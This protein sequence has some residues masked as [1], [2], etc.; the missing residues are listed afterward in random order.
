MSKSSQYWEDRF[1]TLQDAQMKQASK[2]AKD[3][4]KAYARAMFKVQGDILTWYQRFADNNEISLSE[5]Q[6]LLTKGELAEFKWTVEEYIKYGKENA[7]DQSYMKQLEN[8]SARVHIR[9]LEAIKLQIQHQVEAIHAKR[10][11]DLE[12]L[13]TGIYTERYYRTAYETQLGFNIGWNID[14]IDQDAINAI[15]RKPW[16]P[17]GLDFSS[18]IWRDRTRMVNILQNELTQAIIRG[19]SPEQVI[20]TMAKTFDVSKNVAGRLVMTESAFFASAAQKQAMADLDVERYKYV[21]TLDLKTSDICQEMDGEIFKIEQYQVNVTAPPLH[22]W[23]RST[24][25]P[26]F[27]DNYGERAARGE[28]GKTHY[29]PN[30]MKYSEW[31][32]VYVDKEL[33]PDQWLKRN[34]VVDPG[35]I[36]FKTTSEVAQ[37]ITDAMQFKTAADLTGVPLEVAEKIRERYNNVIDRYPDL[38]GKFKTLGIKEKGGNTYAS[39]YVH[40][41]DIN[42][43][44]QYFGDTDK[45]AKSYE[46]DLATG[47]HPAGTDAYSIITHEIGHAV[48]GYMTYRGVAEMGSGFNFKHASTVIRKRALKELKM[49]L[50]DVP[51]EV[52]RYGAKN[53]AEFFAEAFAEFMDSSSPRPIAKKVG[54]IIDE[55]MDKIRKGEIK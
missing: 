40:N 44:V 22:A 35:A 45:L 30:D 46:R 26:Y 31:K 18:R 37:A 50:K 54:E 38:V 15:I 43:N 20:A 55:L 29:V 33:S 39:C 32:K 34:D 52:S 14:R 23:C 51:T 16:A 13:S 42:V 1:N 7:L 3:L 9:R 53:D 41:G 49:A 21:A 10:Y 28:D 17:D 48:D 6:Q 4:E 27:E 19:D 24:T 2:V 25:V 11:Q 5:A 36:K 8:A 12:E 47:F